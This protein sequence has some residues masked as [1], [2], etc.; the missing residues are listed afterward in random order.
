MKRLALT[1]APALVLAIASAAQAQ[2]PSSGMLLGVYA[3]PNYQG[4]RVTGTMHGYSAEGRLFPGDVMR[5]VTADGIQMF[6][7]RSLGQFEFA[8]DQIG[9]YRPAALEVFR[10]GHGLI[11]LWVEFRPI[12]GAPALRSGAP[13]QMQ[14][15]IM[16]EQE[17]PGA[18]AMFR[19][20]PGFGPQTGFNGSPG[21]N[22]GNPGFPAAQPANNP[23]ASIGFPLRNSR[24]AASLFNR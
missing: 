7:T 15:R 1:I 16:T 20:G 23:P 22:Q 18:R 19:G 4:L 10:P 5:R 13:V 6:Q 8:K 3:F 17:R 9:P 21:C 11:Y 2:A 24:N 12:G 14:A